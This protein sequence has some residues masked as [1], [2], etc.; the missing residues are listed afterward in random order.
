LE[1]RGRVFPRDPS[2]L[3]D[4]SKHL[5]RPL[6]DDRSRL[7]GVV[8]RSTQGFG[9]GSTERVESPTAHTMSL[10]HLG[11]DQP[12]Q[13]PPGGGFITL[14]GVGQSP[15][16]DLPLVAEQ[17]QGDHRIDGEGVP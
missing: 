7:S 13:H 14:D 9:D 11:L 12:L 8:V 3:R 17:A 16:V 6:M 1:K 10:D 15:G 5:P 4:V 2:V